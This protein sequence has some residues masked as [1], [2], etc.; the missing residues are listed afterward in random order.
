MR[1]LCDSQEPSRMDMCLR[2]L[3]AIIS[4]DQALSLA[5][6]EGLIEGQKAK[7]LVPPGDTK[8]F[9]DAFAKIDNAQLQQRARELGTLWGNAAAVQS[10]LSA[11]EDASLPVE[12]RLKAI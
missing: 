3:S 6:I 8:S 10:T 4:Q 12:E 2:F 11:I 7:P 5:A 9:F 1:R